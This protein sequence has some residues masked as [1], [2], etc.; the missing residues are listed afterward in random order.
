MAVHPE[1]AVVAVW[2]EVTGIRNI[3]TAITDYRR[4]V[5]A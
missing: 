5:M 4:A 1:G 2:E 3:D